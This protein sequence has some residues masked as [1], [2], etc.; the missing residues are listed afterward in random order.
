MRIATLE[1]F[2]DE[3]PFGSIKMSR[4]EFV[5]GIKGGYSLKFEIRRGQAV[6]ADSSSVTIPP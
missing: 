2:E 3:I 5:G 4:D 6:P 1:E